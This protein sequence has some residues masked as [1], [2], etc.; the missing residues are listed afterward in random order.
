MKNNTMTSFII[1]SGI[2]VLGIFIVVAVI[3]VMPN[4]ES[5]SY[6][7]KVENDMDAKIEDFLIQDGKLTITTSGDAKEY[8]VKSTRTRPTSNSLCWNDIKDNVA[9]I[10]IFEHKKYYIWIKDEEGN[11]SNYLSV[12]SREKEK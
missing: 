12:N 7:V 3:N 8:C 11:I 6:Y 1:I 2:I 9:T 5:D 4:Y 10:S